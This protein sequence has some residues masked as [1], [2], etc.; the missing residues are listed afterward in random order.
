MILYLFLTAA[1]YGQVSVE[2]LSEHGAFLKQE[3]TL[4]KKVAKHLGHCLGCGHT[5]IAYSDKEWRMMVKA[6]DP[7][8][9][10]KDW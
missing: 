1:H 7:R 2:R 6:P 5:I 9:G 3:G 10:R 8:C 4:L